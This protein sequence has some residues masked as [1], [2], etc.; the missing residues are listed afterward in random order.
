MRRD[1]ADSANFPPMMLA[2]Y[3]AWMERSELPKRLAEG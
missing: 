2:E 3:E 1:D